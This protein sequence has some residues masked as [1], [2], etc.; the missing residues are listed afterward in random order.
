MSWQ[1]EQDHQLM[2]EL[3]NL[4]RDI[5]DSLKKIEENATPPPLSRWTVGTP[6]YNDGTYLPKSPPTTGKPLPGPLEVIS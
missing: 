3:V 1:R 5:R 6:F 2:Q 4:L